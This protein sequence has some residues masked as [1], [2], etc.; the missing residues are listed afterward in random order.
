MPE[1]VSKD[2][3][4]PLNGV[5]LVNVDELSKITDETLAARLARNSL[6]QK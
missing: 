1:N 3:A 5:S 4:A 2:V 6:W